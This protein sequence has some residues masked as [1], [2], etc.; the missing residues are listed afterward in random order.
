MKMPRQSPPFDPASAPPHSD[1][2]TQ[3][4]T[5]R[6]TAALLVARLRELMGDELDVV[7]LYG[8]RLKGT[9]RR[10]SDFDL[11]FIPREGASKCTNLTVS[12]GGVLF[13]LYPIGWDGMERLAGFDNPSTS[14]LFC[15]E[16]VY[17]R[18]ESVRARFDALRT[19]AEELMS[20]AGHDT[21]AHKALELFRKLGP[22]HYLLTA[23]V[24]ADDLF[25][26]KH[27]VMRLLAGLSHCLAVLNQTAVDTRRPENLLALPKRPSALDTHL[28]VLVESTDVGAMQHAMTLLMQQTRALVLTELQDCVGG[29]L[30][31]K[32]FFNYP[33][34][35]NALLAILDATE[36]GNRY[37]AL[38]VL[39]AWQN[40]LAQVMTK[41]ET[42]CDVP[43][44]L[45]FPEIGTTY[46][47][48]GFPDLMPAVLAGDAAALKEGIAAYDALLRQFFLDNDVPLCDF[49]DNA[50]LSDWLA[51]LPPL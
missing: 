20:P 32:D 46:L 12:V 48:H 31:L 49:T 17:V 11:S 40:E 14:L 10:H 34:A 42:G 7:F 19:R 4:P 21:M 27:R 44:D 8:S 23:Q 15:T 25:T 29:P 50:A 3:P 43:D 24:A 47:T 39:T 51:A 26:A 41:L 45:L 6:Q 18:D 22:D 37:L 30:R 16:V 1:G 9:T 13:D 28:A 5:E 2:T 36:R 35:R 38:C 33:E